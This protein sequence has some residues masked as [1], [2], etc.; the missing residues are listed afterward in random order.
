MKKILA[1]ALCMLLMFCLCGCGDIQSVKENLTKAGYEV[2]DMD[3]S[4]LTSLN[5]DVKY[6]YN[7]KGSIIS[8]FYAT[9]DEGQSVIGVEF[10]DNNDMTVMYKQLKSE[11]EDGW[12]IDI[13]GKIV[14]YGTEKAVKTA[15]K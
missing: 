4:R 10:T 9:N 3:E 15:L 13:K 2:N 6:T 8:G 1:F 11:L 7:G 5:N 14:I 12:I